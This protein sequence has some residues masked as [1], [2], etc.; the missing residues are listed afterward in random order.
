MCVLQGQIQWT[1]VDKLAVQY[2]VNVSS[3]AGHMYGTAVK[4]ADGRSG[5]IHWTDCLYDSSQRVYMYLN[6]VL[7]SEL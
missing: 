1:E 5:P 3:A 2:D 6:F 7:P 4:L